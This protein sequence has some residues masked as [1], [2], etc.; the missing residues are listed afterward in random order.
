MINIRGYI[1][2]KAAV[3]KKAPARAKGDN[4]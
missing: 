4:K 3:P 1:K 2:A